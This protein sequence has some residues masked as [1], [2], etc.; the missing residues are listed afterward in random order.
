MATRATYRFLAGGFSPEVTIYRHWDGYPEGAA[1]HMYLLLTKPS[2]GCMATQFIRADEGT[3]ITDSHDGHGDTDYRYD[4][5][6]HGADAV[7]TCFKRDGWWEEDKEPT[8]LVIAKQPLHEFIAARTE[9]ID[10]FKPWLPVPQQYS[11]PLLYN[12]VTAKL[13]LEQEYGPLSHLRVWSKSAANRNSAN[14]KSM[15]SELQAIVDVFPELMT[16]EIAGF[17]GEPVAV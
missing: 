3:E 2:K 17:I 10:D 7:I 9:H 1:A 11:G 13:R 8:W 16:E 14:W 6:G 4:I 12:A 15:V 5:E